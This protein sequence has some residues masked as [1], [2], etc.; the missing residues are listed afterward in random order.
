MK[1]KLFI[2]VLLLVAF[3]PDL[4]AQLGKIYGTVVTEEG[5]L[6][7]ATVKL[8]KA[9]DS[10]FVKAAVTNVQG[11]FAFPQLIE[12]SYLLEISFIGMESYFSARIEMKQ[13][14]IQLPVIKLKPRST[15][16]EEVEITAQKPLV[17]VFADKTVFN[18]E[19]SLNSIGTDG[20]ELLRKAPG[21]VMDNNE[22]IIVE[23]KTG[24]QIFINGKP[25][26]L[27]G[28]D[29]TNFLRALQ[30]SDI[31]S[32]EI[33]TQPSSKFDAAGNA[34]IIN[35]V[36]KKDKRF[37]TNGSLTAGYAYGKYG[38]YNTSLNLNHRTKNAVVFG[39]YSH[40]A[41]KRWSFLYLDRTQEGV[42]YDSETETVGDN[43]G[44]NLRSG[45]DFFLNSKHTVGI[46]VNANVYDR[47][48]DGITNTPIIP[49]PGTR[50]EQ[51]L[52]ANNFS[53][54]NNYN[55]NGNLNYRYADTL[56]RELTIDVDYGTYERDE[57]T[58]QPNQY[59]N[60][61]RN[62]TLFE[63]NF[64][65][66]TLTEV[67]I[68]TLKAD[69]SSKFMGG[70]LTFGGKYSLVRTD[71]DF[72]FFD[73]IDAQDI[74][75]FNRSNR[76]I[77]SENINAGY[78][79]FNKKGKKWS[80]QFGLRAEQTISE[81]DLQS[82]Q[83]SE[84]NNVKRNY[85]DWFPSGGLTF[86]PA[87][88]RSWALSYSRRIQ[89][90]N[91]R[92]LNP[93]ESQLDELS[94]AKGNPFLQPQ[95]TDNIKLSHTYNF[96]LTTSISY[97]FVRDFFAQITDTLGTTRNF[98]TT[99]NIANQRVWNIGVSYPFQATKWWSVFFSFNAMRSNYVARDE[100]Y[101]PLQQN[102]ISFYGQNTFTL[103]KGFRLEVSGWFNSPYIWGGTYLS[104]SLGSLDIAIQKKFLG[105]K[106][107]ARL[108]F[109][110]I[111]FSSP[112][113]A[114]MQY[115]ELYI[116]G[117]G[118]WESRQVRF[119]LNYAFGRKE[120]KAARKRKTGMDAENKRVGE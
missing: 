20:M 46:L 33:I 108:A 61:L 88:N 58:D 56:G 35:I 6:A 13:E 8:S 54:S 49:L 39:T 26:P 38:R 62:Q 47:L 7:Y 97:S 10:S 18:V 90:P 77:Y 73:I 70:K 120:I 67:D 109:S 79:N 66:N 3:S 68:V 29:L 85:L 119:D 116:N 55:L 104:K 65:M 74:L 95:Y 5:P 105:D 93:F 45:A 14:I 2:F 25:S 98:I 40:T 11:Q 59:L 44:H 48:S 43:T 87:Y 102:A 57:E 111:L 12:K 106:L 21:V 78:F 96:R 113:R 27:A 76:F 17:S 83:A 50:P 112:W 80:Y 69:Y 16:L 30:A 82:I 22:N 103:P 89:R 28:T 92:T 15:E 53:E 72:Q 32:I 101:V 9:E 84:Q 31:E 75:N 51:F 94:F 60:G 91:Y 71:N 63:R 4:Q 107:T 52:V 99:R 19:S 37:G 1:T 41:G 23:G 115:G 34:G 114:D 81:G 36:L 110:D 24:V 117:T 100:K 86:A 118:G 42:R 64:G